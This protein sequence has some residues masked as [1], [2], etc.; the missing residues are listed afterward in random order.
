MD[1]PVILPPEK[2]TA[3][4]KEKAKQQDKNGSISAQSSNLSDGNNTSGGENQESR[5]GGNDKPI[6]VELKPL[7][8]GDLGATEMKPVSGLGN[9]R[10]RVELG[11]Y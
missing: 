5:I 2:P 9:F 11:H 4:D 8:W 6:T 3:S 7:G 1:E 10:S